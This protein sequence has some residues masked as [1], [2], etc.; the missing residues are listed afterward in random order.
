MKCLDLNYCDK[1]AIETGAML[2][3]KHMYAAMKML[4]RQFP[5]I[6]GFQPTIL[7]QNDGFS[8]IT[9]DGKQV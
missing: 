7:C 6:D 2:N 9:K 8:P 4:K 1:V 3:D 5:D